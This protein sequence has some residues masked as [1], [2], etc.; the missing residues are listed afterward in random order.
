MRLTQRVNS[1]IGLLLFLMGT[2]GLLA[3]FGYQDR[4]LLT[5]LERWIRPA[6]ALWGVAMAGLM[7]FGLQLSWRASHPRS[8]WQPSRPGRRFR[9]VVVYSR[10]GCHLCEIATDL[11]S[12][13]RQWLPEV[14]EVNIDEDPALRERFH[15]CVPVIECDGKVR[16]RGSL[17]EALLQRLIEGTPPG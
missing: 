2:A 4:V 10:T 9:S 12:Q 15:T 8:L 13:Y 1:T 5:G 17:N 3:W 16:F 6:P 7:W 11:L 14:V